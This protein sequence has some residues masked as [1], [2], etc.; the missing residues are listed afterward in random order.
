MKNKFY[1]IIILSLLF[2]LSIFLFYRVS[3]LEYK[4]ETLKE[5][6]I[7]L[8]S[9]L[10][11]TAEQ[12]K[13][14]QFKEE[15]Y[16]KQQE[17]DTYLILSVFTIALGFTAFF[18]IK[19]AISKVEEKITEIENEYK[20]H[21]S[22]M[23]E[24]QKSLEFYLKF[25]EGNFYIA[26]HDNYIE[27]QNKELILYYCFCALSS[28]SECYLNDTTL[29]DEVSKENLKERIKNGLN[30]LLQI[31]KYS[32]SVELSGKI[33]RSLNKIREL[34]D[35]VINKLLSKIESAIIYTS[36]KPNF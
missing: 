21:L 22:L 32:I 10:P 35:V 19:P 23:K 9:N 26:Q 30:N 1:P 14:R 31:N 3:N 20:E 6:N 28:F 11:L 24:K 36:T 12:I 2:I 34:D 5:S 29:N 15:M 17:R 16:I 33:E 25:N 4:Y 18:T 27:K 8:T 13:E 7:R